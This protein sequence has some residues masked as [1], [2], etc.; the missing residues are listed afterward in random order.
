MNNK[1][2]IQ[3]GITIDDAGNLFVANFEG[4]SVYKIDPVLAF[5]SNFYKRISD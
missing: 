4:S 2:F 1:I 5:T 3:S